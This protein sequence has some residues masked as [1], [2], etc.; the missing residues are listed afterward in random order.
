MDMGSEAFVEPLG[1]GS[2]VTGQ[3][4]LGPVASM[5]EPLHSQP[6]PLAVALCPCAGSGS[7][8]MAVG[9]ACVDSREK[10]E[11]QCNQKQARLPR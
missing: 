9:A 5:S 3:R 6:Q 1:P 8:C 7:G 11:A 4:A 2:H 10:P